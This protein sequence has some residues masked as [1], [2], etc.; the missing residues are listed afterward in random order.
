M[1]EYKRKY[2]R[3]KDNQKSA[4]C[5]TF[6]YARVYI[7]KAV[8]MAFEVNIAYSQA[9]GERERGAVKDHRILIVKNIIKEL[10]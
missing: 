2:R 7:Y 1:H 4:H 10:I 3:S 9:G 6:D 5:S 8:A